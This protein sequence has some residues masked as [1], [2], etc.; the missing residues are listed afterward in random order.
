VHDNQNGGCDG[1][2]DYLVTVNPLPNCAITGNASV[3]QGLS[4]QWSATPGMSVYA[5]STG[6][7][8]Q[9]ITVS[10]AATYS[11][12][13]TDA[14]GCKS[15]CEKTLVVNPLPNCAITGSDAIATGG[16]TQWSATAGMTSYLWSTGATTQSITVSTAATYSVTITNA[17]GCQSVCEKTLLVFPAPECL[18]TGSPSVC[19]GSSTQWCATPGMSSY[20]W[21]TGATTQC[22]TVSAA[23]TYS[24]TITDGNG[25]QSTCEGTLVLNPLPNCAITGNA[26]VCQ[27]LSTQWSA[28]AGMSAYAWSTGATTQSI[29]VSVAATYSVTITN[30][31]GCQSICEKTLVVNPCGNCTY[32]QGYFGNKNGNS[33]DADGT[34]GTPITYQSPVDLLTQLLSSGSLTVGVGGKSI[35]IP[36]NGAVKLNSVMP[37]GGTPKEL[38]NVANCVI[39]DPCFN[40]Y[41]TAQGKINNV[42]L[43]Q[44]ITLGLNMR[45]SADLSGLQLQAGVLATAKP[46]G[47]CGSK[48]PLERS[49]Y[50]NPES[51]YNLIVVNE[52]KYSTIT[53]SV[54]DALTNKGYDK[55][56]DGLYALANDALANV[57]GTIGSEGGA[58]LSD[59]NAAVDAINNAFDGCRIFIGWDVEPCAVNPTTNSRIAAIVPQAEVGTVKLTV[60]AYPNPFDQY[61]R[62][63]IKS[64]VSGQASLDIYN[65]LGARLSTPYRGYL[66]AGKTEIVNYNVPVGQRTSLI[67]IMRVGGQQ[68]S[69]KLINIKH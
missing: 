47:G 18:I 36:M 29:T 59:I 38:T 45:I 52:Y 69:G 23:A 14:N 2:A 4:T 55:T 65:S 30:E 66:T 51:P 19:T 8:T 41:L 62:F 64:P 32:T 57:D 6:A 48:T 9:S 53:A 21:S 39:T 27:G 22:I 63:E 34:N 16:S 26:S 35:T 46:D 7:T 24:V 42:L 67:Y 60:S 56:V 43:S 28:T 50:T 3:C 68:T 33:C 25:L 58:S 13:I 5:W 12:T 20:L 11:V 44:T 54:I 17:N 37:G 49:C 61:I 15:T 10:A 31:N 1:I 40:T